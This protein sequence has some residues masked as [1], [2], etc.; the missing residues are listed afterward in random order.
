MSG[1]P[2]PVPYSWSVAD[3]F[4]AAI[5]NGIRDALNFL[6]NPPIFVGIQA[7]TQS[8]PNQNWVTI[9][10]DSTVVDTYGGHSN[11]VNNTRYTAPLPG[12]YTVCGVFA[13]SSNPT[14]IRA[15]RI[16][17]NGTA[18]P[19]HENYAVALNGFETSSVTPTR[20]IYLNAGDY[21]ELSGWQ[22]CGSAL[23]TNIGDIRSALYCRYS[24]V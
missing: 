20:D 24:H 9:T 4:T 18:V 3:T 10:F 22:G 16:L 19:G 15:A 2:V 17:L 5:G 12:W 6:L 11:S 21:V 7:T 14:S 1:L 23:G 13:T 8:M